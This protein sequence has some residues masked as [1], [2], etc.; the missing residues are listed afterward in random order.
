MANLDSTTYSFIN[1]YLITYSIDK[2]TDICDQ[3][4]M[5]KRNLYF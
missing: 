1:N 4:E 2:N 3:I 5:K